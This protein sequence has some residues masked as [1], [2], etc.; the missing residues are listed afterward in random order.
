[1]R[2][3]E[4]QALCK[5][6]WWIAELHYH[7]DELIFMGDGIPMF[8]VTILEVDA[9]DEPVRMSLNRDKPVDS[10]FGFLDQFNLLK[11]EEFG[12]DDLREVILAVRNRVNRTNP[13]RWAE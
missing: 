6:F 5:D 12:L 1:M 4:V 3:T 13:A 8:Y 11:K 10:M 7:T 9:N 2:F